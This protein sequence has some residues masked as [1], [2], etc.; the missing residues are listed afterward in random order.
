MDEV[1]HNRS[2]TLQVPV[3]EHTTSLH[4]FISIESETVTSL[5]PSNR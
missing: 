3:V 4:R 2:L 1:L 5:E